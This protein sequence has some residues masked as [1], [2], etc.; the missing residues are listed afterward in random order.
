M[1]IKPVVLFD[2]DGV[3]LDS[4]NAITESLRFALQAIDEAPRTTN[5]L[6]RLV[7]PPLPLMI[8]ELLP[9]ATETQTQE[10]ARQYREHNNLFGPGITP[11]FPGVKD[12]LNKLS[13]SADLVI[14]TSKL[15]S[16]AIDVLSKKDI[17]NYFLAINGS[18]AGSLDSKGDV[19]RR[20]LKGLEEYEVIAM[21]G[22]RHHDI[23][24][25]RENNLLSIG[26]TWGYALPDE[27]DN[28]EP[29]YVVNS[30]IELQE[31]LFSMF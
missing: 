2:M 8:S 22:D 4:A 18:R 5:E 13:L 27:L 7:G 10:F 19:I 20:A 21:V 31:L 26:V 17:S 23:E 3:I 9:N 15:E 1:N 11:I 16:A 25:A 28:A 6:R 12:L 24:G 14:A 30:P 29:N